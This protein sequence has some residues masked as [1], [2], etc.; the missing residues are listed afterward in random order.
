MASAATSRWCLASA[1][2][3]RLHK[4]EPCSSHHSPAEV[5]RYT[6]TV[7]STLVSTLLSCSGLYFHAYI[8]NLFG[9]MLVVAAP[10]VVRA[11]A[12]GHELGVDNARAAGATLISPFPGRGELDTTDYCYP[13]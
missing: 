7:L 6:L 8:V 2:Q 11:P 9:V 1:R 13:H 5:S 3:W 10:G 4:R 12:A